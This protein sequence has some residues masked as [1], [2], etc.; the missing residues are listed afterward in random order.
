MSRTSMGLAVGLVLGLAAAAGGF[1]GF[2][3]TAVLGAIGWGVGAYLDG[4][5]DFGDLKLGAGRRRG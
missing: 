3:I 1:W 4:T 5:F 2:L